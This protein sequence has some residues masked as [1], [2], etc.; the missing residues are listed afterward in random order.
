MTMKK[1]IPT[2]LGLVLATSSWAAINTVEND[3]NSTIQLDNL[4][5]ISSEDENK[6]YYGFEIGII[7]NN[8]TDTDYVFPYTQDGEWYKWND[9]TKMKYEEVYFP[10][11]DASNNIYKILRPNTEGIIGDYV[12]SEDSRTTY[13]KLCISKS[14]G[15]TLNCKNFLIFSNIEQGTHTTLFYQ[16]DNKKYGCGH[17]GNELNTKFYILSDGTMEMID[18]KTEDVC[19]QVY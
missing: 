1:I 7:N 6:D 11:L 5:G 4:M 19:K 8:L 10:E 14:L 17:I 18:A 2:L 3:N 9:K 12:V 13:S 15:D 16:Y